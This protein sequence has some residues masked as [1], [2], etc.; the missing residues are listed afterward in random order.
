MILQLDIER[1]RTLDEVRDFMAGSASCLAARRS[2]S[3]SWS[4]PMRTPSCG[5]SSGA[6]P[7]LAA[8]AVGQ[9][10]GAAVPDRL[11]QSVTYRRRLTVVKTRPTR[12]RIGERRKPQPA[13]Q[14]G[15]LRV[16]TVHQGDLDRQALAIDDLAAKP[17]TRLSSRSSPGIRRR[18]AVA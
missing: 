11:R 10:S 7:V 4:G 12:V 2:T 15:C 9:G 3:G 13:G 16:D 17:S 14:P 8:A 5:G 6:F 18:D 1:L